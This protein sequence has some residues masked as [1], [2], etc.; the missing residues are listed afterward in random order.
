MPLESIDHASLLAHVTAD[1]P[2]SLLESELCKCGY[3]LALV[4]ASEGM[5]VGAWLESGAKGAPD[6]WH[7]PVDQMVAGFEATLCDGRSFKVNPVPRRAV[8][9]D[10]FALVFG[11]Q[12]AVVTLDRIWIRIHKVD[13][14]RP[15]TAAFTPPHGVRDASESDGEAKLWRAIGEVLSVK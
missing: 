1:T 14:P 8:G 3:T 4:S 12:R 6:W 7:D 2:L 11:A 10:L 15:M 9:P 13:V 5:A